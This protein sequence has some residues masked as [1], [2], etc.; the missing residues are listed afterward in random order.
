MGSH[1]KR[2][3]PFCYQNRNIDKTHDKQQKVT[4]ESVQCT[5]NQEWNTSEQPKIALKQKRINSLC[6][7]FYVFFLQSLSLALSQMESDVFKVTF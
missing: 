2:Q 3:Q 1:L 6:H 7:H 5:S 4:I